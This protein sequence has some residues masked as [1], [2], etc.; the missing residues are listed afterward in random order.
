[1]A[2]VY[3]FEP[4]N[5]IPPYTKMILSRKILHLEKLSTDCTDFQMKMAETD[6]WDPEKIFGCKKEEYKVKQ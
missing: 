5:L 2:G 6:C 1:V 4:Q 3:L